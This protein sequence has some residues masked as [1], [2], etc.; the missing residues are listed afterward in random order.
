MLQCMLIR[1]VSLSNSRHTAIQF[2]DTIKPTSCVCLFL[3]TKVVGNDSI[4]AFVLAEILPRDDCES[5]SIINIEIAYREL[6]IGFS[7]KWC[8]P[9][10]HESIFKYQADG[11]I[12]KLYVIVKNN[13]LLY[14]QQPEVIGNPQYFFFAYAIC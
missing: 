12:N 9:I 11:T 2:R 5:T 14:I 3:A 4:W 1:I 10:C 6:A 7:H 8:F 13:K